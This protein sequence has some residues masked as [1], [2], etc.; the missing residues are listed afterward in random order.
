[1]PDEYFIRS[2]GRVSGP[3]DFDALRKLVRR[4][5]LSRAHEI[6]T[7]R[8]QWRPAGDFEDL[9]PARDP[10]YP[11][12][13]AA[14]AAPPVPVAPASSSDFFYAQN[15]ETVGPIPVAV[16]RS[17]AKNGTIGPHDVVWAVGAETANTAA[18]TPALA[19][20]F[21]NTGPGTGAMPARKLDYDDRRPSVPVTEADRVSAA[22]AM[23][24]T[25][26]VSLIAGIVA[27]VAMLLL[28]NLPV[29]SVNGRL[30]WWWD[31]LRQPTLGADAV[32]LFYILFSAF[33]VGVVGGVV[34]GVVRGWIFVGVAALSLVLLLIVGTYQESDDAGYFFLLSVPYSA[35][36][37]IGI[38]IFR[39][40]FPD[41]RI[42]QIFQ[43][44][45]GG[46]L[47]FA[48]VIVGL[49]GL[50]KRTGLPYGQRGADLPGWAVLG[51]TIWI[52]GTAAALAAGVLGLVGLK[53]RF[54]PAA[55]WSAVGCSAAAVLLPFVAFLILAGGVSSNS[56]LSDKT[57]LIVF[58]LFRV[59]AI[60]VL[61][62]VIE[63]VGMTE[64]FV[65]SH[66][67]AMASR[68]S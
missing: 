59:V 57:G 6:S 68:R 54:T 55:N 53:R 1:M 37:L 7:D 28:L 16:L 12:P 24:T 58:T 11:E 33:I 13:A 35:A 19:A 63:A 32:V 45:A 8:R 66:A 64:I 61:Y 49:I 65:A 27:G 38:S 31:T 21:A 60:F 10:L 18:R 4:S 23:A 25:G 34:R 56:G 51:F 62:L 15:G 52:L 22:A 20:M 41:H 3:F 9:F 42:G 29:A 46:V 17:L 39:R 47:A 48:T 67:G 44:I 26:T 40:H 43:G 36:A 30:V 2:R 5:M 50:I 14:A